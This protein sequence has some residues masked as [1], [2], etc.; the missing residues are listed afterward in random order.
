[1]AAEF[2]LNIDQGT[3]FRITFR[4]EAGEPATPV[5]LTG[6]SALMHIRARMRD[7]SPIVSA[8]TS[9]GKLTVDANGNINL[10]LTVADTTLLNMK[11]G[12]YDLEV[13][14]TNGDVERLVAGKVYVSPQVTR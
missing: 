4:W 6:C 11:E 14:L 5:D 9:N 8:S 3:T 7:A 12:V 1:M 13:T 10:I 2:D